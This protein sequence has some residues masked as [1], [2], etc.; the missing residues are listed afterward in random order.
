MRQ[1]DLTPVGDRGAALSGGQR[2]RVALARALYQVRVSIARHLVV[3][4]QTDESP[5]KLRDFQD[6]DV[7]F[8][9]DVLAAVDPPVAAWLVQNAICG[10][11]LQHKTRILCTHSAASIR[12]A[13][14]VVQMHGGRAALRRPH[15]KEDPRL[16]LQ[17]LEVAARSMY[18]N[19]GQKLP[20]HVPHVL[21]RRAEA[22]QCHDPRGVVQEASYESS[23]WPS[24][25]VDSLLEESS[26]A[27]AA[28]ESGQIQPIAET[29]LDQALPGRKSDLCCVS[30]L[31]HQRVLQSGLFTENQAAVR[32][33]SVVHKGKAAPYLTR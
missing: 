2:A 6:A 12:A 20:R 13:D 32:I 7:Y 10:P 31:L 16:G 4:G 11:L 33:L 9:D 24:S 25:W 21:V 26:S 8:L 19:S 14:A 5:P 29:H 3:C 15:H 18:L 17:D 1:A 28:D 27:P 30:S 23:P 22:V